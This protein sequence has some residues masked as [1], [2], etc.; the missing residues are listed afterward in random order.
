M[1]WFLARQIGGKETHSDIYRH[2]GNVIKKDGKKKRPYYELTLELEKGN[3][4]LE[5][6]TWGNAIG[7]RQTQKY[8]KIQDSNIHACCNINSLMFK[9]SLLVSLLQVSSI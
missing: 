5:L 1:P 7:L 6:F 2:T 3:M 9:Y 8:G 4:E